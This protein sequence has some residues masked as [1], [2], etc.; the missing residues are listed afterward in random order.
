MALSAEK[1]A[2]VAA[3]DNRFRRGPLSL[4][5][6]SSGLVAPDVLIAQHLS[7]SALHGSDNVSVS[8]QTLGKSNILALRCHCIN[9]DKFRLE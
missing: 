7:K 4:I 6:T 2:C 9:S 1:A 5:S 3:A 8:W